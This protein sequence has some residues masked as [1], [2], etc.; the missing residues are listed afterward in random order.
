MRIGGRGALV[1]AAVTG[2]VVLAVALLTVTPWLAGV[3][4]DDGIYL[5]LGKSL[6]TGDG[7]R[8]LNLPGAPPGTRYPP[9]YPALLA[10]LWTIAPS[11]PANV[12]LFKAANA[13]LL[14]AG[15]GGLAWLGAARLRLPA[16][17]AGAA[18]TVFACAI[19][20][21]AVTNVLFSEPLFLALLVPVL[22]SG[23]RLLDAPTVT[24]GTVAGALAG[25]LS[26]VR[27]LGVAA[28]PVTLALLLW[29]RRFAAATAFAA[30]CLALVLPWQ[31]WTAAHSRLLA[32]SAAIEGSYG[33]YSAW[34]ARAVGEQ[35]PGFLARVAAENVAGLLR[36]ARA[37]FVGSSSLVL[38]WLAIPIVV[39]L[40]ILGARWTALRAPAVAGF[41]AA[42]LGIV[43]LWPFAPD[44]FLWGIWPLL[45]L[46][47]AAGMVEV[48]R[49]RPAA[50]RAAAPSGG[51]SD[52]LPAESREPRT[53]LAVPF[54][55]VRL[56]LILGAA[57]A[58]AGYARYNARGFA[59][60]W[61][62]SAQK[63]SSQ[64]AE[65]LV[66]WTAARTRA[67]DIVA[68]D[69]DPVVHLYTG[70]RTVPTSGSTAAEYLTPRALGADAAALRETLRVSG[71]RYLLV[72]SGRA[73]VA[74]AAEALFTASP[75]ELHLVD[76]LPAGGA[77]FRVLSPR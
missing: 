63:G 64:S 72:A 30:S 21:L 23:D 32:P 3:F 19:P 12:T 62:E 68:T 1:A 55:L 71:A 28:V 17:A 11:F 42:Y 15:A 53:P 34:I 57:L 73:P 48:V 50:A 67:E 46:V 70:R 22:W 41:L 56:T 9:G 35:G 75:P 33:P 37:M 66:R 61:W 18:A 74:R 43:V 26:L 24:R 59:A 25:S 45:G 31:L 16:A 14:A 38:A 52:V 49:W 7:Y 54:P 51:A 36:I 40:L 44:R 77:A 20:V 69:A 29:R 65:A 60:R 2:A 27:T 47:L 39:V 5:I 10:L 4:Y 8:Y 58:L 6:A 76:T 13:V